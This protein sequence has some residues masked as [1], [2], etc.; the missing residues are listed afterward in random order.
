MGRTTV[1]IMMVLAGVTVAPREVSAEFI[2][3]VVNYPTL[4][5]GYTITGTITTSVDQGTRLNSPD[6]IS[7]WNFT[8]TGPGPPMI[9][10]TFTPTTSSL[11]TSGFIDVSPTAITVSSQQDI[12]QFSIRTGPGFNRIA[13]VGPGHAVGAESYQCL[14]PP[15][16]SVE[17]GFLW[18][19]PYD[20]NTQPVAV[21]IPEPSAGVLATIGAVVVFLAY[22]K[23]FAPARPAR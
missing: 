7:S 3:E 11:E 16:G 2:Y 13:W 20:P 18:N 6:I 14:L 5:N 17:G 12:L 4:Q 8:I 1:S 19:S 23:E 22:R 9:N 21:A 10:T 15:G